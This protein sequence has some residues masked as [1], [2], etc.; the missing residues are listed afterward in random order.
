[1]LFSPASNAGDRPGPGATDHPERR[2]RAS[3]V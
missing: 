3:R 1:M 2:S